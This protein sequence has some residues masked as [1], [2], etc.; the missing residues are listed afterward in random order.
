[1]SNSHKI[2]QT[3]YSDRGIIAGKPRPYTALSRAQRK[4]QK[5]SREANDRPYARA[6]R[7]KD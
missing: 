5:Q 7:D 3:E 6:S 1:M 4:T 2:K